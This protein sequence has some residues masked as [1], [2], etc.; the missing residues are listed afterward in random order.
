MIPLKSIVKVSQIKGPTLIS[1]FN[2][3]SAVKITGSASAGFSSGEALQAL[4]EVAKEV[5]PDGMGYALGGESYQESKT[6]GSSAKVL[7]GGMVM[8]FLVLSALYENFV[9][10][11]FYFISRAIRYFWSPC[12]YLF[13]RNE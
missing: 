6:G 9:L 4:E 12:C 8:V 7:I 5:L 2:G 13:G 10:P 3:F 1:R 11:F